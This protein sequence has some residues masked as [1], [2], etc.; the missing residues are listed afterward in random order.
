MNILEEFWYGNI[1]PAEYDTSSGKEYK[2]LLRLIS[3]NED[4]LLATMTEEQKELYIHHA[5]SL[6][7][8]LFQTVRRLAGYILNG[9]A[10]ADVG[11]VV[12][13]AL[14]GINVQIP[15]EL[16]V[17]DKTLGFV[18]ARSLRFVSQYTNYPTTNLFVFFKNFAGIGR[19]S[20]QVIFI[21]LLPVCFT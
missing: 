14:R 2:E 8:Q 16:V 10:L 7:K 17:D 13:M 18:F 15:D 3:R 9:D 6:R 4:K 19:S 21:G 11:S 20:C 12:R 1:E 5:V